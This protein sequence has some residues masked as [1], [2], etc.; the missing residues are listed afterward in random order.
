VLQDSLELTTRELCAYTRTKV[1]RKTEFI[2]GTGQVLETGA[3]KTPFH[4]RCPKEHGFGA[5]IKKILGIES[6]ILERQ[7]PAG[8]FMKP[9]IL[10]AK[11]E[12]AAP[13]MLNQSQEENRVDRTT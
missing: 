7:L 13:D 8:W 4:Q 10:A 12:V 5:W 1:L 11:P 3:H 2:G 6:S 9:V